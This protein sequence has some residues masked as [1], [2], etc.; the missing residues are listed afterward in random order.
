[1]ETINVDIMLDGHIKITGSGFDNFSHNLANGKYSEEGDYWSME[2]LD[3]E[4]TKVVIT[5]YRTLT[6][7]AQY[8]IGWHDGYRA[9]Y[10]DTVAGKI[11]SISTIEQRFIPLKSKKDSIG[12]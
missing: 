2:F 6:D 12:E 1:M 8:Q 11:I 4:E 5:D 7:S 10:N 3:N 9:S